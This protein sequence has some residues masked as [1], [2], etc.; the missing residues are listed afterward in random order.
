MA[1]FSA[2]SDDFLGK[3]MGNT[4]VF[5]QRYWRHLLITLAVI[6]AALFVYYG[7]HSK[8]IEEENRAWHELS[9]MPAFLPGRLQALPD[10]TK[11]EVVEKCK[12][13]LE[14]GWETSATPWLYLK[15]AI[16]Q[17][18]LGRLKQAAQTFDQLKERY[19]KHPAYS[20]ASSVH[21]LALEQTGRYMEAAEL[22]RSLAEERKNESVLLWNNAARCMEF[23]GERDKAQQYY[24]YAIED[25][26]SLATFPAT[27]RIIKYRLHAIRRGDSLLSPPP[28][29][30]P[31]PPLPELEEQKLPING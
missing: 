13:L 19:Q 8:S 14:G 28:N 18:E 31:E 11:S 16:A 5:L 7:W 4:S 25:D 29:I 17:I 3:F 20:F 21:A 15:L 1:D 12:A 2:N 24:Q 26:D 10:D 9:Q 6:V 30:T 23:A 27:A 22:Y